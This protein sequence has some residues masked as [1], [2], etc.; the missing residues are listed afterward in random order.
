[1]F[2]KIYCK[3][4]YKLY[5]KISFEMDLV[6]IHAPLA[7]YLPMR[8]SFVLSSQLDHSFFETPLIHHKLQ[9]WPPHQC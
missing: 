3:K 2:E 9:A 7:F 4:L 5:I 8:S 1:M 6:G